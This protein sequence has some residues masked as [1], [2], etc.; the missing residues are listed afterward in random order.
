MIGLID[1]TD[2]RKPPS[3]MPHGNFM[4]RNPLVEIGALLIQ[5]VQ[6]PSFEK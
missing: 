3:Q 6:A 2:D 4:H 5:L 1:C